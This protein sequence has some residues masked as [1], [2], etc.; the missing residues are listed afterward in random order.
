M[1]RIGRRIVLELPYQLPYHT[2]FHVHGIHDST[3]NVNLSTASEYIGGDNVFIALQDKKRPS[4]SGESVTLFGTLPEDHLPGNHWSV[5]LNA[6]HGALRCV[7][8]VT[9]CL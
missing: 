5:A 7:V 8:D 6:W 1:V 4:D 9:S 2:N 3:G